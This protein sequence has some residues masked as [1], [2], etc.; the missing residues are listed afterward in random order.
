MFGRDRKQ[1]HRNTGARRDFREISRESG[2]A[3]ACDRFQDRVRPGG[4]RAVIRGGC[5]GAM[6]AWR[7]RADSG[8]Q[9]T[10]RCRADRSVLERYSLRRYARMPGPDENSKSLDGTRE[11]KFIAAEYQALIDIDRSRNERLD[12]FLTI[13]M[14]L[15][16]APWALYA[17]TLKESSGAPS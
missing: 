9:T 10:S 8:A 6:S 2:G 1:A 14:T 17:L 5:F 12:R 13:F 16:A 3:C 4:E 7:D 11:E 15:A